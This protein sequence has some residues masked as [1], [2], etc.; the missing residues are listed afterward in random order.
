[1]EKRSVNPLLAVRVIKCAMRN[2]RVVSLSTNW[3]MPFIKHY[4]IQIIIDLRRDAMTFPASLMQCLVT[5]LVFK[6]PSL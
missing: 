1:M 2:Y 3:T 6:T 5:R 4:N